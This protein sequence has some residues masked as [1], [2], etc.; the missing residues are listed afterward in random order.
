MIRCRAWKALCNWLRSPALDYSPAYQDEYQRLWH[1]AAKERDALR[2]RLREQTAEIAPARPGWTITGPKFKDADHYL[3]KDGT[4]PDA[5]WPGYGWPL[6]SECWYFILEGHG[7]YLHATG[8]TRENAAERAEAVMDSD[9][10]PR[11]VGAIR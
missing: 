5:P 1:A 7:W 4:N 3:S 6:G 9:D 2:L 10:P 11:F 8:L